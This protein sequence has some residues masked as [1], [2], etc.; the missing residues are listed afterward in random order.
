[1]GRDK[2]LIPLDG[3]P[4]VVRL[5]RVLGQAG[6]GPVVAVGGDAVRMAGLGVDHVGDEHPG[7][8]PLGGVLTALHWSPAPVVVVVAVD[9]VD[10]D[11]ATVA[12]LVEAL[13]AAD[14][15][16]ARTDRDE[17]LCAAWAVARCEP[18][19]RAAFAAGERAVHRAWTGLRVVRV[20]V[21]AARLT[22]AN[23]PED[24]VGR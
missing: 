1:M 6:A 4:L 13:A 9:L 22:N 15:A 16:V 23:L 19:V 8:G 11:P 20:P 24:L 21:D 12:R 5:A 10:L 2:A 3:T 7:A 17:P 18:A 14:V